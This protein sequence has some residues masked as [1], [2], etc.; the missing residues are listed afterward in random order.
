M[1]RE[2]QEEGAGF[3][4]EIIPV[5]HCFLLHDVGIVHQFPFSACLEMLGNVGAWTR[6][7]FTPQPLPFSRCEGGTCSLFALLCR[8]LCGR[9]KVHNLQKAL[10]FLNEWSCCVL[11]CPAKPLVRLNP[12]PHSCSTVKCNPVIAEWCQTS[13]KMCKSAAV[14][15]AFPWQTQILPLASYCQPVRR[16]RR[17]LLREAAIFFLFLFFPWRGG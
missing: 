3:A 12:L 6:L 16:E 2:N 14:N 11:N 8:L 9:L 5:W 10:L 1:K 13:F 7:E 17:Q 15:Q 4:L